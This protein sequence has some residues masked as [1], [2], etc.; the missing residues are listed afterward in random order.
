MAPFT[1]NDGRLEDRDTNPAHHAWMDEQGEQ[2]QPLG[3]LEHSR[4][5]LFPGPGSVINTQLGLLVLPL[6]ETSNTIGQSD[7][8]VS[9]D[10]RIDPD[11]TTRVPDLED[12]SVIHSLSGPVS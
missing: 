11:G 7:G 6:G 2:A 1:A 12:A 5:E 3:G 4:Q 10:L 8:V 9:I